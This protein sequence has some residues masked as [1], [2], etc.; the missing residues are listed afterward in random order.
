MQFL[1]LLLS[2]PTVNTFLLKYIPQI[3]TDGEVGTMGL[4]VKALVAGI[5]FFLVRKML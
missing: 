4:I 5:I 2:L 3:A 1:P